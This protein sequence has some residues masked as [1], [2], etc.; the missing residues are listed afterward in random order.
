MYGIATTW[1]CQ[2]NCPL[3]TYV[4]QYK[5]QCFNPCPKGTFQYNGYCYINKQPSTY[6]NV[7]EGTSVCYACYSTC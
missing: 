1:D 6:C 3:G 5:P 7:I 4:M 2:S